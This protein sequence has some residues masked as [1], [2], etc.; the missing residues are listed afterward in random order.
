MSPALVTNHFLISRMLNKSVLLAKKFT[1]SHIRQPARPLH[2]SGYTS[3][4]T[5]KPF[6][7]PP[8]RHIFTHPSLASQVLTHHSASSPSPLT[9]ITSPYRHIF[10]H[11][12]LASQ[13]LTH[14]SASSPSPLTKITSP[15]LKVSS[16]S[17]SASQS[18]SA[19]TRRGRPDGDC[20]RKE[21]KKDY[22][23]SAFVLSY[24]RMVT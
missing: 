15:S 3:N 22:Q 1:H 5:S 21:K 24:A 11:P 23:R 16:S 2:A 4:Y 14:H 12:S 9:K 19:C 13:V 20:E 8:Y 6:V 17:L 7:L 10:T 18:Y